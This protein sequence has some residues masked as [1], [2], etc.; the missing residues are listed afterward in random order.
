MGGG[1]GGGGV[2]K[3]IMGD[4]NVYSKTKSCPYNSLVACLHVAPSQGIMSD[5]SE[6]IIQL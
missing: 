1:G 3:C 6:V 2:K 5:I 4:A